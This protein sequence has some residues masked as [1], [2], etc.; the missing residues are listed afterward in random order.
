[1]LRLRGSGWAAVRCAD[2]GTSVHGRARST[3]SPVYCCALLTGPS[4]YGCG[5]LTGPLCTAL[6]TP[7]YFD[8]SYL[9]APDD[10]DAYMAQPPPE[11]PEDD[12]EISE[13]ALK[14]GFVGFT[15]RKAPPSSSSP[16][17]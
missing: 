14:A 8:T 17:S 1:M 4:V 13:E 6:R 16:S 10:L 2:T 9:D 5:G 12:E 3:G 15:F 7:Q 11:D